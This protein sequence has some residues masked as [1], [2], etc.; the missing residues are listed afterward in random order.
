MSAKVDALKKEIVDAI[1]N[2]LIAKG[3]EEVEIQVLGFC[4]FDDNLYFKY[5]INTKNII[6]EHT[7][8]F[9]VFESEVRELMDLLVSIESETYEITK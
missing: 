4:S 8:P 2:L 7:E 6:I 3:T 9:S 5:N 1:D